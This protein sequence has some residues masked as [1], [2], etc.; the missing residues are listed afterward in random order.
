MSISERAGFLLLSCLIG[1]T[2]C[3]MENPKFRLDADLRE[4]NVET[5][6]RVEGSGSGSSGALANTGLELDAEAESGTV[7]QALESTEQQVPTLDETQAPALKPVCGLGERLCYRLDYDA[8]AQSYPSYE[9]KGPALVLHTS[10]M[11]VTRTQDA[12]DP[13]FADAVVFNSD[14]MLRTKEL[15]STKSGQTYGFLGVD[16]SARNM[17]CT[18]PGECVLLKTARL[19]LLVD[20]DAGTLACALSS[21]DGT[22]EVAYTASSFD[23]ATARTFGCGMQDGDVF[24]YVNGKAGSSGSFSGDFAG[25]STDRLGFGGADVFGT[26]IRGRF[27][28]EVGLVRYWDDAVAMNKAMA[29]LTSK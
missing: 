28:G 8:G 1:L 7:T 5:G 20:P 21:P 29:D 24:I 16:I 26:S 15:F 10:Q 4:Q 17:R 19:V 23:V 12:G 2:G 14:A 13:V 22:S 18:K 27:E 25:L 11:A 6:P 9:G 3:R